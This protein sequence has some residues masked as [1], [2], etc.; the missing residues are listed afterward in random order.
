[1]IAFSL[2]GEFLKMLKK[3]PKLKIFGHSQAFWAH[4]SKDVDREI[5]KGYP[6]GKVEKGRLWELFEKYD[7]IFGDMSAGGSDPGQNQKSFCER[8]LW[9]PA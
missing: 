7:N 1:M 3:Y 8:G 2:C 4:M 9:L 5:M 6:K